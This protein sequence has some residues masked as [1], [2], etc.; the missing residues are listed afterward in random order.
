[1]FLLTENTTGFGAEPQS[2]NIVAQAAFG[3]LERKFGQLIKCDFQRLT[4]PV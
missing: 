3:S 1:M 4:P 2:N